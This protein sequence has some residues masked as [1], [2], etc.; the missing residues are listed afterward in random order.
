M[1]MVQVKFSKPTT[2]PN[3]GCYRTDEKATFSRQIADKIVARN[4]GAV[5][6]REDTRAAKASK[7]TTKTEDK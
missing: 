5:V 7:A 2:I 4:H 1:E 6:V 3:V